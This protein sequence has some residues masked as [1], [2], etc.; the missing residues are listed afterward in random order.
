MGRKKKEGNFDMVYATPSL[1]AETKRDI[2]YLE[3]MLDGKN[4]DEGV[5]GRGDKIVD[6]EEVRK[7][8]MKKRS[9]IDNYT[10]KKLTGVAAN[11]A[12]KLAKELEKKIQ[13]AMPSSKAY[14]QPYATNKSTHSRQQ[15][16]EQS[17]NQQMAFMQNQRLQQDI[18]HY[19]SIMGQLD[20]ANY[21]L[22]NIERLRR[23]R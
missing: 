11:R 10:P 4:V 21:P 6:K 1:I 23:S 5:H 3:N 16:F 18:M 15:A 7:Q 17:V 9:L 12:Y 22:R 13:E 8:L 19:R 14:Y 20:P 2:A